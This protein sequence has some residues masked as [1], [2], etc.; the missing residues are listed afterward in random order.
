MCDLDR[1][2]VL[3]AGLCCACQMPLSIIA[4]AGSVQGK[5]GCGVPPAD[6]DKIEKL[7][8][9]EE[10]L[11]REARGFRAAVATDGTA[12]LKARARAITRLCSSFS[13]SPDFDFFNDGD[14]E[15]AMALRPMEK[16][17]KGK[18]LFGR[19]LYSRL[20]GQDPAGASV[21][22]VL[23]HEFG[24]IALYASGQEQAVQAGRPTAKRVELHAD[25][26]AG[27]Y[28]GLRKRENPQA[29]LLKAGRLIW[30]LGDTDFDDEDHHGKPA[31]RNRAAETGFRLG[32]EENATFTRAFVAATDYI[33]NAYSKDPL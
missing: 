32:F 19:S 22:A 29:S 26:L 6:I 5:Y 21:L 9:P 23:A 17:P 13:V 27:Y 7:I 8:I 25:F 24:H 2:T 33:T 31:E 14:N 16:Y 30:N 11:S 28:L 4:A 18:V 3:R 10:S 1:R 15:N 12:E 20:M